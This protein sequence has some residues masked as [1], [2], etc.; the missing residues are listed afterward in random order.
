M[1]EDRGTADKAY[2]LLLLPDQARDVRNI[3]CRSRRAHRSLLGTTCK[4]G[5]ARWLLQHYAYIYS[6]PNS[7]SLWQCAVSIPI[8]RLHVR[9]LFGRVGDDSTNALDICNTRP[10]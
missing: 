9:G 10:G 7:P 5:I 6:W 3:Q 4:V 2:P 8:E 1:L